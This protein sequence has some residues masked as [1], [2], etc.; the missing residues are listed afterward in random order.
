MPHYT[1]RRT[2]RAIGVGIAATV[3]G[4]IGGDSGDDTANGEDDGGPTVIEV[5]AGNGLEFSPE[6]TAV[7]VGDTVRWVWVSNTHTV[8]PAAT[9]D[10]ATWAGDPEINDEGHAYEHAFEVAGIYD[11]Y[12]EPH[13]TQGMSGSVTVRE[14]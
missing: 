12:C 11:Y 3:A 5:G 14:E 8:T 13:R 2:L 4:C 10:G 6:D 7:A 1:R 9:P